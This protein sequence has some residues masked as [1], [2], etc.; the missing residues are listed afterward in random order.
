M[1]NDRL[2]LSKRINCDES[3]F[4]C[5][6]LEDITFQESPTC[7]N[8]VHHGAMV[9]LDP[10]SKFDPSTRSSRCALECISLNCNGRYLMYCELGKSRVDNCNIRSTDVRQ[11]RINLSAET[12]QNHHG[13]D[14][15][16]VEIGS[17]IVQS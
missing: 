17:D 11:I 5:A 6:N 12:M 4:D 10:C 8:L 7:R 13:S 15:L 16:I 2:G 14:M 3:L 1:F 9:W